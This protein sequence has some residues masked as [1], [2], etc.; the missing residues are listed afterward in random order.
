MAIRLR[1]LR[2]R[3][4]DGLGRGRL[5]HLARKLGIFGNVPGKED[6][7][8]TIA[9]LTEI[10][11]A[12]AH[13]FAA[14][15]GPFVLTNAGGAL[16]AGLVVGVLYFTGNIDVNTFYLYASNEDAVADANRVAVSDDGTG[17]H[18]LNRLA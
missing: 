8:F 10:A 11:T 4:L 6:T 17:T 12:T 5:N 7:D 9:N 1:Y 18:T 2:H 14:V 3:A 13:G 15:D 16:P